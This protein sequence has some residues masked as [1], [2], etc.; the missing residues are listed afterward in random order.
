LF[1]I[2]GRGA[3]HLV[4]ERGA[5]E[6]QVDGLRAARD[7]RYTELVTRGDVLVPGVLPLLRALGRQ[8]RMAIVTSSQ[9]D[10]FD[11]IHRDTSLPPLRQAGIAMD[12]DTSLP[13]L[14]ELVLT[15]EDYTAS[16]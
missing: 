7:A 12:R 2:E 6:A 10:H 1:L 11:A 16:K 13:P 9:R 4:R 5:T 3:W 8:F 15:C 14:F